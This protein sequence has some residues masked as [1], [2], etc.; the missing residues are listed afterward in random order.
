MDKKRNKKRLAE[1]YFILPKQLLTI[2]KVPSPALPE[3]LVTNENCETKRK[4]K[5]GKE[6]K[7]GNMDYQNG[8]PG[9]GT[10][11]ECRQDQRAQV[12]WDGGKTMVARI[13]AFN[14]YDLYYAGNV[15]SFNARALLHV[16][17]TIYIN[18]FWKR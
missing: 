2:N 5:R 6:W 12:S 7:W 18:Y 8:T 15:I 3:K 1:K 14:A 17:S 13:G 10:I 11:T 9:E 4:V 16:S